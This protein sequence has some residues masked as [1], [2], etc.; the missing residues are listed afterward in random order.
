MNS[1]CS[2]NGNIEAVKQY[3]AAGTDVNARRMNGWTPLDAAII[4]NH[5]E[6]ADLLRKHGGKTG[7]ELKVEGN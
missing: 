7:E 5:T 2:R 3:L 6:T 4:R 1:R